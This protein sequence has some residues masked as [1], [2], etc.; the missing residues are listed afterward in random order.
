M[1]APDPASAVRVTARGAD[2][3][4]ICLQGEP[5]EILA[6]L[7]SGWLTM[8]ERAPMVGYACFVFRRHAIEL[9]DLSEAEATAFIQDLRRASRAIAT[10]TRAQ[11][12]NW[13]IHGNTLPHLHVHIFPR[14]A[15][16]RFSGRPIDPREVV[17][18]VYRPGEFS[19]VQGNVL[20][21]LD[22]GAA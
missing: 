9:H 6:T 16:D 13:E 17:D 8:S 15:G 12:L 3:C 5:L 20:A 22:V 7:S 4:P 2:A 19:A 21:S 14:Y 18:P 11:K 10:A 1:P